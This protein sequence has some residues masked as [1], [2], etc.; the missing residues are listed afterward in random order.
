[1]Q[2]QIHQKG[3]QGT[4]PFSVQFLSFSC[5]FWLKILQN[6]LIGRSPVWEI[7]DHPLCLVHRGNLQQFSYY[8]SVTYPSFVRAHRDNQTSVDVHLSVTQQRHQLVW[9][10]ST[11][12]SF[13]ETIKQ[14]WMFICLLHNKDI[15]SSGY[16]AL[17]DPSQRQSNKCGC[18][19]VC[20]T[21]K[22]SAR[23]DIQH[24]QI[25][26]RDNQTSVD[27]HLSVT[28]QRHQLVWIYSTHRSFTETI[29][30][31]WMFICLLHNK[32]ISS[33]G[34]TALIDPSQRQS[35]KCGCS[36]VCYTTKTSAR[37]DIQHSQIL[38]RDNQTSVD[39]H[40]SVTQQRHQLV[41]IYST[42]RSFTETIK[43]VWM[44]ICLLHNK[45]I[46]SSGYTALIDPSQRQSNKCGC[47]SVCYTTKTSA[48]L[49]IQHSQ[50]LHRDN[51]TSV[52]VHLSV[53]QQRHQLV[54][55]YSTHRSFTETIKQVWMFICLLH[56]KDISSSGYT[57]L[58][59]PSQRQSNKCGCSSV[60][61]TTKTSARLDIQ[62]SQ[63]L[64]RD[65]QTSVDVHLSVTQQRHQLVW[66]YST[67]RS[68]TE[69]I[70]Q[71]WMFI[72]LLHNKDISSSGYT[73]LIDPSQRQSNKCGCSSVCYTTK[74]SA[75][76]DIQHSQIL[77]RDNQ[78]S[79]DVHLSVTQQRH[80]LVWI[81]ST[82]RS[83]TETI[84]QVWMFICLLH[85]KDISSSGYTALIDP[86]QRQSNKCGC[87]SVC[88]TT[89]TSA[90]L[91]IQH[92][93][94]LHRDNQTSVD[95]HLSVTQQ[96]HQLVWIYST[97]RSFTETIKQ[98][99]MFICLLHNKDISSSGYTALIDPSQRQSNKCGCSSV[100]YTTKTSARLD[101]QHSQ[102]LHRDNQ[103]SVDV[104]LSVTQ[105]RHQ[106]VWIY[107]THRS[108]TETIKQVW[109]FICLL[110]NKQISSSGYTALIDPSQRQSNKCGCSS[111]CYTTKRLARLDIR[112]SQIPHRAPRDFKRH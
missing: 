18:S 81:Y 71:V 54:W 89:K 57:A 44:F 103:T 11:H 60:C 68:F 110:H 61:Y 26:H 63:I 35:N 82:H 21:T 72:C 79:V 77:H 9:I 94:I 99:W 1:M 69:T 75:R 93:Q 97:H 109:M 46:S 85:N 40:L 70:K 104:H 52:D 34:Y 25:L 95:V 29:K 88:Y 32:D 111:V 102:I 106:L 78:T 42:H 43:Q 65:N 39:V 6:K 3:T 8:F 38:H 73:A 27:V 98:V 41:W 66:I 58:I 112:H 37:L 59:D 12:R 17:I 13:T 108:F 101:I 15:S 19:S 23:L 28:Q 20:Y 50:I 33:S 56:N 48:R 7:L 91:D 24:S 62:H 86:S 5:G 4:R 90:R 92:S 80:Q 87:S 30:Q 49:D 51:Q 10:Y 36:S 100:C 2:L 31:V 67:H 76:L 16:T 105:Q 96:R 45:D 83:F 14:V 47:S 64:H 84:K 74:T 107:S 22:T 53:T 55:I